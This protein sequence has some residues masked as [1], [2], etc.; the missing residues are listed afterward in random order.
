MKC[1]CGN[2]DIALLILRVSVGV[3]FA[4]HGWQKIQSGMEGVAGFFGGLSFFGAVPLPFPLFFAYLITGIEF[5]GGIALIL[6][7]FTHWAGK[8]LS[9]V[10]L[11]AIS[12]V[13]YRI[14]LIAPQGGGAGYELDLALLAGALAIS[15]IGPGKYTIERLLKPKGMENPNVYTGSGR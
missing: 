14:G 6:G 10:M 1:K 8:L 13:K 12:L 15:W 11:G 2:E 4:V 3:I 9:L 7:V 5:L